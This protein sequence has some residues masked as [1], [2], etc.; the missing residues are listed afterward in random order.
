MAVGLGI[1]LLAGYA[2]VTGFAIYERAHR[3][4]I[5]RAEASSAVGD[6]VYYAQTFDPMVPL[7]NFQGHS[8]YYVERKD[9]LDTAMVKEGMD[10]TNSY[11]IYKPAAAAGEEAPFIYLKIGPNSYIKA[12]R[13]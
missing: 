1:A 10:D 2:I 13:Q 5:E 11:A 3:T 4:S 12:K 6:K 8:F 7:V 9:A